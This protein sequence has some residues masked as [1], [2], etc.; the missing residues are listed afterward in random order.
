MFSPTLE[1]FIEQS[2]V[3]VIARSTLERVFNADNLNEWFEKTAINQYTRNLLFSTLFEL[4]AQVVSCSN[5]S[6]N[7]AYRKNNENIGVSLTAIY[8]KLN[9]LE[10][11][12]S[13]A[14]VRY[15]ANE[16]KAIIE[17]INGSSSCWVP[18]YTTK[19]IDGNCIEATEHRIEELRH[20][21]GGPLPG[22]SLVVFNP[23]SGLAIDTFPCENGH[24][25]ERSLLQDVLSTIKENDLWIGDRNFC[26]VSFLTGIASLRGAFVIREHKGLPWEAEDELQLVSNTKN[27]KVYEQCIKVIDS[28]KQAHHFRRIQ[29]KLNKPTRGGE[30]EVFIITNLPKEAAH[31]TEIAELYRKRWRL[32]TVFQELERDLNS[33][34]NALGYPKAALFSFSMALVI[35]NI[36]AIIKASIRSV[37]GEEAVEQLSNYYLSNEISETYAGMLIA[38]PEEEWF[39]FQV[40]SKNDFAEVLIMLTKKIKLQKL[41]KHTRGPK[42]KQ[43]QRSSSK[44]T[45]HVSTAKILFKRK[46]NGCLN[47]IYPI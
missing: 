32:E 36:Y 4:M 40:L 9:H 8:N 34:I 6:V 5:K 13:Q 12:T 27:G 24:A 2:P 15:S 41:R 31:A 42:K 28:S 7:A 20:I 38:V 39:N 17:Q 1:R 22:K 11:P 23:E 46:N 43:P 21:G 30:N 10:V 3:S 18:G 47:N 26:V 35:N 19:I 29:V 44:G 16:L 14:L 37:H 33:E 25:Q 45:P